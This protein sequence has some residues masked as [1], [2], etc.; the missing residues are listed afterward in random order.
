MT[1][2]SLIVSDSTD[3]RLR[4]FFGNKGAKKG[5]LSRFVEEAVEGMLRFEETITTVQ[6]RNLRYTEAQV[7]EDIHA[8]VKATRASRTPIP[9]DLT[10]PKLPC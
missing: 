3:Q 6:A 5:S 1:R 9:N 7:M 8:A 10:S 4:A 2:W